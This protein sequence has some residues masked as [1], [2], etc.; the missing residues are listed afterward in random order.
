MRARLRPVVEAE[1]GGNYPVQFVGQMDRPGPAAIGPA[2]MFELL[3]VHAKSV[4]ELGDGA[5][6]HNMP[7]ARVLVDD[8]KTVL[9]CELLDGLDVGQVRAELFIEFLMGQVTL[10]LV[11]GDYFSD[12]FL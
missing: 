9:V 12:S 1:H 6:E 10:A 7:P 5:G 11:A 3:Q 2:G 4:I 8:G